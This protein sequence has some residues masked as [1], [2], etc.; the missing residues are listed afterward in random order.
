MTHGF[1][2]ELRW[3]FPC[4]EEFHGSPSYGHRYC[5]AKS[6]PPPSVSKK[7][8]WCASSRLVPIPHLVYVPLGRS[9]PWYSTSQPNHARLRVH[10][11][12]TLHRPPMLS[13]A[14]LL[15]HRHVRITS[16]R[17]SFVNLAHI[18]LSLLAAFFPDDALNLPSSSPR[19]TDVDTYSSPVSL[20]QPPAICF[21]SLQTPPAVHY[22]LPTI[23]NG[24]KLLHRV[25]RV[26]A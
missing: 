20:C 16:F 11:P 25:R 4:P 2:I 9:S 10:R 24:T 8:I 23:D 7:E 18:T 13:I 5:P 3:Q 1:S 26:R 21:L 6:S 14:K 12:H 22:F 15:M 17:F 19:R